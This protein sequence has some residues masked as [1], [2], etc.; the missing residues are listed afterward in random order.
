M[1]AVDI[2]VTDAAIRAVLVGGEWVEV[3]NVLV[4]FADYTA[5]GN[6]VTGHGLHL[7]ANIRT[8]PHNGEK[9]ISPLSEI[10]AIRL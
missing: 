7:S 5:G 2:H 9:L 4:S 3:S 10:Q 1:P 8:G 6:T